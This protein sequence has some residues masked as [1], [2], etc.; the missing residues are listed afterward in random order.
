MIDRGSLTVLVVTSLVQFG[1]NWE[2]SIRTGWQ[3]ALIS[4]GPLRAEG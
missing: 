1:K 3:V 2:V 4:I